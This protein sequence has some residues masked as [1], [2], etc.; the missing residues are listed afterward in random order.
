[1]KKIF[2]S[3]FILF[4]FLFANVSAKTVTDLTGKMLQL[5]TILVELLLFLFLGLL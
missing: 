4:L 2:S 1:M 5:K 3:M